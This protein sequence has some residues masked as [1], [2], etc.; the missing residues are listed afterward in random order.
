[1]AQYIKII[2]IDNAIQAQ[3]LDSVL[4][5][6]GI[7]HIMHSYYDSAYDGLF[8]YPKG[9]GHVEAP[10][11]YRKEILDIFTELPQHLINPDDEV[12]QEDADG[13]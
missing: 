3:L 10:K 2:V 8:Q 12:I 4:T 7:P 9:W 1:M 11:K 5:E 13:E 6:R